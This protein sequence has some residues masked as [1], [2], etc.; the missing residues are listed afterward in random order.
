MLYEVITWNFE[1]EDSYARSYLEA[2]ATHYNFN[3]DTPIEKLPKHIIDK[4]LYG[5]N[6]EKINVTYNREN[7][8]GTFV[9]AF[10]GVI[11]S[12]ERRS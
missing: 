8:S 11:T 5:T 6:G 4:I 10:E 7:G 9:T 3:I 12:M 1:S 2:L